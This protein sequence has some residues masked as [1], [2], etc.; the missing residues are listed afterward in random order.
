MNEQ[1]V[2]MWQRKLALIAAQDEQLAFEVAVTHD[3]ELPMNDSMLADTLP[4]SPPL[5]PVE[6]KITK[7]LD[8]MSEAVMT[9]LGTDSPSRFAQ[10]GRFCSLAQKLSVELVK[11]VSQ[12]KQMR[13]AQGP[14]F[15][16]DYV[17]AIGYDLPDG[18]Q[19]Y[20]MPQM[21]PD[22]A[23]LQNNLLMLAQEY[24]QNQKK[25]QPLPVLPQTRGDLYYEM[26]Q[27]LRVRDEL[28]KNPGDEALLAKVNAQ[29]ESLVSKIAEGDPDHDNKE[30]V[31][32]VVPAELLRG[33]P[34]RAGFEPGDA[35]DP[36]GAVLH[37]EA[38]DEVADRG[39][40]AFG[41]HEEAVG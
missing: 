41:D 27:A 36:R 24:L 1:L 25:P 29:I 14:H 21:V 5:S 10:A 17:G 35:A 20:P 32:H 28:A 13:G 3:L 15:A 23:T 31:A 11:N 19:Q 8:A 7:V 34:P 39:G 2:R 22:A 6:E 12:A 37:R 30:S 40:E 38:R 26:N 18:M 16:G 4:P 33:H 9:V